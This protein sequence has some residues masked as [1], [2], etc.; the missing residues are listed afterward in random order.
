MAAKGED[1][2]SSTAS[3][4]LDEGPFEPGALVAFA[5]QLDPD[6]LARI[7]VALLVDSL[8]AYPV[9]LAGVARFGLVVMDRVQKM[10]V[11]GVKPVGM[12][13][14][15]M[16]KGCDVTSEEI[17]GTASGLKVSTGS[18]PMPDHACGR[19]PLKRAVLNL[20]PGEHLVIDLKKVGRTR[21]S[22][23]SMLGNIR[24][25]QGWSAEQLSGYSVAQGSGVCV[26]RAEPGK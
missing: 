25:E 19:S 22:V 15:Q 3:K 18:P 14:P 16:M 17:T 5:E 10:D 2:K 12:I 1:R 13:R 8:D 6:S 4:C 11:R 23:L 24:R 21:P 9:S 26:I 20:R 7:W